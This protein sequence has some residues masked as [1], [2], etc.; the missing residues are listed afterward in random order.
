MDEVFS[1]IPT[2]TQ[3]KEFTKEHDN[4]NKNVIEWFPIRDFFLMILQDLIISF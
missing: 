2:S 4:N 1:D 3:R